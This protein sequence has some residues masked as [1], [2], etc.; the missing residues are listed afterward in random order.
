MTPEEKRLK[1]RNAPNVKEPGAR[2]DHGAFT[3]TKYLPDLPP[4]RYFAH[5]VLFF[6]E[7]NEMTPEEKAA[8]NGKNAECKRARRERWSWCLYP[9][10]NTS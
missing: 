2:G 10:Q 9:I 1:T 7:A 5:F 3:P 8:K 4:F 6:R